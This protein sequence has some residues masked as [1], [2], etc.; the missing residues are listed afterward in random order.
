MVLLYLRA[1]GEL[2]TERKVSERLQESMEAD[3]IEILEMYFN[4]PAFYFKSFPNQVKI[5]YKTVF[6]LYLISGLLLLFFQW[7]I[8]TLTHK[9]MTYALIL[10]TLFA[11]LAPLSW[12][13]IFRGHSYL[14]VHLNVLLWFMPFMIFGWMIVGYAIELGVKYYKSFQDSPADIA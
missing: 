13:I 5:K 6:Y 9:N 14:H 10:G 3:R 12:H 4:K 2:E 11:I 8:P 7:R 1:S